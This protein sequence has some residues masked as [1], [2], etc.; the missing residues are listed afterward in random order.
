MII[1]IW[2]GWVSREDAG[3]Y[4]D[5]MR[6][7]ALPGYT[8]VAGNR[9]LYMLRRRDEGLEEFCMVTVWDSLEAIKE[10]AGPNYEEAVFYPRDDEYLVDR[11]WTVRHYDIYGRANLDPADPA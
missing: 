10:F 11:E 5:Y 1:R 7:V 6:R 2:C 9:G 4:A 8:R 3:A